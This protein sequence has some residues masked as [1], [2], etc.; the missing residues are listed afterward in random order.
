MHLAATQAAETAMRR[1]GQAPPAPIAIE[2]QIDTGAGSCAIQ[3]GLAQQLN[4]KP[5][6]Q[7]R[8]NTPTSLGVPADVYAVR[9]VFP[10]QSV[11][12]LVVIEAPLRG[13]SL[14]CLI[15]RDILA[16]GIFVY[17]GLQNEYTLVL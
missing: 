11:L 13:Q 16:G 17:N 3:Q 4:L 12:E 9:L 1:A 2:A 8:L 14:Q 6:G 15:G 5:V 7:A 10:D